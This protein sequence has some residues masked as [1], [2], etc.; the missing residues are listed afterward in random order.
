V[1]RRGDQ[2]LRGNTSRR[3]ALR[4]WARDAGL[5][6]LVA[7][8]LL[9]FAGSYALA[10]GFH[11]AAG[12]TTT[13][14][15]PDPPPTTTVHPQ[16]APPPPPPAQAPPPPPPVYVAPPPPPVAASRPAQ[17][18]V[19]HPARRRHHH[20]QSQKKAGPAAA[21]SPPR[22]PD[23]PSAVALASPATT[24]ADISSSLLVTLVL[25]IGLAA[26]V[27][28]IAVAVTPPWALPRPVAIAIHERRQE[29][30][31]GG[32]GMALAICVSLAVTLWIP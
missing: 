22:P 25:G 1:G 31:F 17:K 4:R 32:V 27:V 19:R 3:S 6:M 23:R 14:P 11:R 10:G 28:S 8:G 29:L 16:P 20:R 15:R 30:I 26:A 13:S 2:A 7:C 24:G 5:V 9:G 12:A 18:S 21:N